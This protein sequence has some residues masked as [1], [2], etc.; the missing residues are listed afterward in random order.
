MTISAKYHKGKLALSCN[1]CFD[2]DVVET[3]PMSTPFETIAKWAQRHGWSFK[4]LFGRH[5]A[6]RCPKCTL[7]YR[8]GADYQR[9]AHE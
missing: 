5:F 1:M 4:H 6:H 8:T 2:A 7:I 9:Y 3:F